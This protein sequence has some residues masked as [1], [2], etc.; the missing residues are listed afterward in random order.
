MQFQSVSAP[1]RAES[2]SQPRLSPTEAPYPRFLHSISSAGSLPGASATELWSEREHRVAPVLESRCSLALLIAL[3][4]LAQSK[5]LPVRDF[6]A[7]RG[8]LL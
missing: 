6:W 1:T 3:L 4:D 8:M 2:S 5:E 7:C